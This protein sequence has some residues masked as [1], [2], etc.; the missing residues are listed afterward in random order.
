MMP[1]KLTVSILGCG[2][3]GL[4]F[5]ESL[6]AKGITVKGSTTSPQKQKELKAKGILPYVIKVNA[7]EAT[8]D[9]DFF[10]CDILWIAI[11]PK[12]RSGEG[13]S[14]VHKIERIIELAVLHKV[15][16][17]VLISSS[18]VYGDHNQEVDEITAPN[19]VTESGKVLL[20]AEDLVRAQAE[21][22][23]TIIRFAGLIGPGRDPGR[24]FAGKKN[25][26]N[27]KAPVNLIHL[28][29]CIGIS[30]AII[31]EQ[32]FGY[33]FNACSPSHP[34][35]ADYYTRAAEASGLEIPE[36]IDELLE[37]KVVGS[38][39]VDDV[40]GYNYTTLI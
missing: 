6:V 30:H 20:R 37:W 16:Q 10:K 21:F 9:A 18:G 33:T 8:D 17:V 38:I 39:Y 19:P 7:D 1:D 26:P 24:F 14:Y 28:D 40:L 34:E 29:D 12:T 15:Q 2:W 11:P 22:T 5:A 25:I 32:A 23:S 27:G 13:D 4:S 31:D 3:Y 35:K 36:F